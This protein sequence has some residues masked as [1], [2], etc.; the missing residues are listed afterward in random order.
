MKAVKMRKWRDIWSTLL[1]AILLVACSQDMEWEEQG[2][3]SLKIDALT[4][5]TT[6]KYTRTN[7]PADYEPMT[8][9][10][11]IRDA[12]G[13]VVMSTDDF[14]A[15]E[16][17][18]N[19]IA[20]RSGQ[21]TIIAHSARW[22]GNGTGF[23]APYYYGSTEVEVKR[24]SLVTASVTCT[25]ANVKITVN[26][27]RS[28][29]ANFKSAMTTITS[30]VVREAP[31][32]FLMGENTMSG[33]IPVGDFSSRLDL[34]NKKGE[35]YTLN[36][37]FTDVKPRDHYL[38]HIKLADE[39][40]MGDE[41]NGG[42]KVEVD[43]STNTYTFTL[44]MPEK[45]SLN[46]V[47]RPA[48][49]WSNFA[50]LGAGVTGMTSDFNK[51]NLTFQWKWTGNSNWTTMPSSEL[52]V[53]EN[54]NVKATLKNLSPQTIYEYRL[55]YIE[56]EN[57]VVGNVV[58]FTTEHKTELYNGGFEHWRM[59]GKVAY[60][61]ESGVSYWDTSNKGSSMA[62]SSNTIETTSVVHGGSKAAMLQSR[63][64]SVLGITAFAAASLYTGSFGGLVGTDG[65]KLKWGVPFTARPTALR[66][67][68]QY[69][70]VKIDNG[71]SN[72][73]DNAPATGEMDQ[74]GMY[75]ALLTESMVVDNTNMSTFPDWDTDPRVV[76]YGTLPPE[77]NVSTNGAWREVN[78]PFVYRDTNRKPAYLLIVFSASK[79]GDYFHG[80]AGSTLYVDDFSL[81]YDE[82][83]VVK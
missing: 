76:A 70:P 20:L 62:G 34:M 81:V 44:Q 61:T 47:T 40:Y 66:G 28:V 21:Y 63:K 25:Q 55:R 5:T 39:G 67:Y 18:Q 2:Y 45:S 26:Y 6:P 31:L 15:D 8:L 80:G 65:A 57:E 33:Y 16:A 73:P 74:C 64:I 48:N 11:E 12:Q 10:V 79:Y 14:E 19:H 58:T 71:G 32:E 30:S 42:I 52:T 68:M 1:S 82:N 41:V 69:A 9:Y 3:L 17:F 4:S 83:L 37:D 43:E 35:R 78:I 46:L 13:E 54:G 59:D 49:A 50:L 23:D 36:T 24:R 38:L 75:C 51:E 27:D 53:D 56:G 29:M 72:L 7:P 77:Q 60:P 22:D